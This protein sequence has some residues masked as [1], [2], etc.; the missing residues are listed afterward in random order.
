MLSLG[1]SCVA[2]M[3]EAVERWT[4]SMWRGEGGWWTDGY[5][6][7]EAVKGTNDAG[8]I[9]IP[10]NICRRWYMGGCGESTEEIQ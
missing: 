8:R 9:R 3:F 7:K 10:R 1:S 5:E 4:S 6:E 2:A